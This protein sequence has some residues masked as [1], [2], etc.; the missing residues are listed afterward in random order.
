M[1]TIGVASV[2]PVMPACTIQARAPASSGLCDYVTMILLIVIVGLF[3]WSVTNVM[4]VPW[5]YSDGFT[6]YKDKTRELEKASNLTKM[7]YP[8]QD[9][10][11]DSVEKSQQDYA[12]TLIKPQQLVQKYRANMYPDDLLPQPDKEATDWERANPKGKGSLQLKNMLS[13]GQHLGVNTQ[14]SSLRNANQ[15]LRSEYPNPIAPVSIWNNSTI[16]PNIYRKQLEVGQCEPEPAK[17]F[18]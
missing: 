6:N 16:E 4:N 11:T 18:N 1:K 7:K 10:S 5:G 14:G 9:V 3:A 13:A 8:Y 17:L 2:N 15:Q 12:K